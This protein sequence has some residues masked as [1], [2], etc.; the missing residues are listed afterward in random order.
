MHLAIAY[1]SISHRAASPSSSFPFRAVSDDPSRCARG[2]RVSLS[3]GLHLI[4]RGPRASDVS[5]RVLWRPAGA[6]DANWPRVYT[7]T[8]CY[9]CK[10]G[11]TWERSACAT[12]WVFLRPKVEAFFGV[13]SECAVV[14]GISV[15]DYCP[16][17]VRK[18]EDVISIRE[19]C[20][21]ESVVVVGSDLDREGEGM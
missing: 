2:P 16:S 10:Y 13:R 4:L 6:R 20:E 19:M 9:V 21:G 18:H 15:G 3:A 14:G 8:T 12:R 11:T 5:M 17:A 7:Y 1:I